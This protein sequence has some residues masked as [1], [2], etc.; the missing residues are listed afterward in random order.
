VDISRHA[1]VSRVDN[2]IC[3][4]VVEDGLGVDSSLMGEDAETGDVVVEGNVNFD[5]L[6][7]EIFNILQLVQLVLYLPRTYS[8]SATIMR[9]M[10]PPRGVMPFRSPIPKTDVSI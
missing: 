8:L 6:S 4:G 1:E 5:S 2:F 3:R 7:H 10:S 9:A